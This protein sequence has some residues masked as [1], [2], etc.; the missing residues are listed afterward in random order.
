MA[1]LR[2]TKSELR[3][4]QAKRGQLVRYLPTLQLK[5]ALL[6]TQVSQTRQEIHY[7]ELELRKKQSAVAEY[8]SLLSVPL[9][10]DLL[11]YVRIAKITKHFENIAGYDVPVFE[12]VFFSDIDYDLFDTPPWLEGMVFGLR[13]I[14]GVRAKIIV[15][16]ER[17]QILEKELREVAIRVN[18]FEKILIPRA[19]ENIRKI[20]VFLGDQML[21]AIS[22]AKVAKMKIELAARSHEVSYES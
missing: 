10:I 1:Q 9:S 7:L 15:A 2:L 22:Q 18:L 20:R 19:E 4:Q 3:V 8:A 11:P 21:S 12:E 5:K 14:S 16:E 6:Q 13:G 17:K